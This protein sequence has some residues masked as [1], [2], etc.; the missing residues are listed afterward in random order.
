MNTD[1]CALIHGSCY[2][3]IPRLP[4]K[5]IDCV[6][7]D[8]PY[9]EATHAN[10]ATER[11]DGGQERGEIDFSH[12]TLEQID[13]LGKWFA[14]LTK[15][16][17]VVFCDDRSISDW[18]R[19]LERGGAEWVRT[20]SWVKTNPAPNFRGDRPG[21]GEE[22]MVV[23]W[24]GAGK[25]TWNG[26]GR[27]SVL[28]GGR[29]L[30]SW[31][32]TQKPV[33]LMQALAGLFATPGALVL[34]PFLGSGSTAIGALTTQRAKGM[35]ALDHSCSKCAKRAIEEVEKIPMPNALRFLGIEAESKTF[36]KAHSRISME[37][38]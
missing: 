7:T 34:D 35:V 23:A 33:W 19:A 18:G 3:I 32:P 17:I 36:G 37:V 28:R 9:S 24:A 11:G 13:W 26:G 8:P 29:D 20:M 25:R 14:H 31:H 22:Y 38:K 6:I 4:A 1:R 5:S 21:Q 12:L 10:F 16:W 30:D 15:N 27:S 2:E